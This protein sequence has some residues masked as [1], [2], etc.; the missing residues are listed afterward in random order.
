MIFDLLGGEGVP[1][2]RRRMHVHVLERISE[3]EAEIRSWA[4]VVELGLSLIVV[5]VLILLV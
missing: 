5:G 1:R 4:W 3:R 2:V